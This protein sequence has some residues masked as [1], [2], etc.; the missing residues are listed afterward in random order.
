MPKVATFFLKEDESDEQP[1][2]DRM[3][4]AGI[5][6]GASST[7]EVFNKTLID[8]IFSL[9]DGAPKVIANYFHPSSQDVEKAVRGAISDTLTEVYDLLTWPE[10]WNGYNACSPDAT[11]VIYAA[12]WIK[13]YYLEIAECRLEWIKPNVTASGDGAVVF[14]WR[15]GTKRLTVYIEDQ[16]AEY[17]KVWGPDVNNDMA[18]GEANL[19][20]TRRA[21]WKWLVS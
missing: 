12:S 18:D 14:G 6:V 4:A 15:R 19:I 2:Y 11:A 7:D 1:P 8:L 17:V 9:M 13:R 10:G 5:P 21:L 16:N 20:G 3:L